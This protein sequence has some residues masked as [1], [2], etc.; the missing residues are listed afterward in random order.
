MAPGHQDQLTV[1]VQRVEEL[2]N[3]HT[4]SKKNLGIQYKSNSSFQ[5]CGLGSF[6]DGLQI[7][8]FKTT[9]FKSF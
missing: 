8:R 6:F 1:G 3:T 4:S 2:T 9:G 7:Q 5:R